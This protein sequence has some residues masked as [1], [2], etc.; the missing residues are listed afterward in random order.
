MC[1]NENGGDAV[2]TVLIETE[3]VRVTRWDFPQ[4]GDC[5]GWH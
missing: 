4:L 1:D 2:E 5:T 3:R